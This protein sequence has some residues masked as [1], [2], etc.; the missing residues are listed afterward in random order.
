MTIR[1]LD[2]DLKSILQAI[3]QRGEQRWCELSGSL[4]DVISKFAREEKI[5][6]ISLACS[7]YF[8]RWPMAREF[9][10]SRVPGIII[11]SYPPI[12]L[13][14]DHSL[15]HAWLRNNSECVDRIRNSVCSTHLKSVIN[16]I[17][18]QIKQHCRLRSTNSTRSIRSK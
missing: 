2:T 15:S 16:E 12:N 6:E 4:L 17:E 1:V 5:E 13:G 7:M 9:V 8:E 18:R 10:T 11:S 14:V 3:T